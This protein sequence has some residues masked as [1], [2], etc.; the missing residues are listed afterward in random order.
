MLL[1]KAVCMHEE[2][3]GILW[4]HSEYRTGYAEVRRW[5]LAGCPSVWSFVLSAVSLPFA[6]FPP[7]GIY[8]ALVDTVSPNPTCLPNSGR[9]AW[10]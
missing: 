8:V 4:K 9:A 2:D 6:L 7:A 10:C 1:K 5:M 3:A